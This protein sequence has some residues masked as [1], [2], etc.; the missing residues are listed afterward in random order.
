MLSVGDPERPASRFFTTFVTMP[1]GRRLG[2]Q[3]GPDRD[4]PARSG[5]VLRMGARLLIF[6]RTR[7]GPWLPVRLLERLP[8]RGAI[9]RAT[10]IIVGFMYT[11]SIVKTRFA[12]PVR[13]AIARLL[14][15]RAGANLVEPVLDA[16]L[17]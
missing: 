14:A 1:E 5:C 8:H 7:V 2:E 15:P 13:A 3:P 4:S 9:R 10:V 11:L 17:S 6:R 12:G 16:R